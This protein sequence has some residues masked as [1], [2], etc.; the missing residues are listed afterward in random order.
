MADFDKLIDILFEK[1]E[2]IL[3]V[4]NIDF[5][6]HNLL[7]E[8]QNLSNSKVEL[9][10][11]L[12]KKGIRPPL[13]GGIAAEYL[14][15]KFLHNTLK[16]PVS[17][18][19][20][21]EIQDKELNDS[22]SLSG[23]E[24]EN[25]QLVKSKKPFSAPDPKKIENFINVFLSSAYFQELMK[26][27]VRPTEIIL[28]GESDTGLSSADIAIRFNDNVERS[29]SLKKGSATLYQAG[30]TEQL[31]TADKVDWY[32]YKGGG[33]NKLYKIFEVEVP[34][35]FTTNE[36]LYNDLSQKL[37]VKYSKNIIEFFT[38][39][40]KIIT[41]NEPSVETLALVEKNKII[42]TQLMNKF[43]DHIQSISFGRSNSESTYYILASVSSASN[44][45][46]STKSDATLSPTLQKI[47]DSL[48]KKTKKNLQSAKMQYE[49]FKNDYQSLSEKNKKVFTQICQKNNFN[50]EGGLTDFDSF[51]SEIKNFVDEKIKLINGK[52]FLHIRSK[53]HEKAQREEVF[54]NVI[55][56]RV[57]LYAIN[58]ISEFF[59]Y[60]E[61]KNEF[62]GL[63]NSMNTLFNSSTELNNFMNLQKKQ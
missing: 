46:L 25:N 39:L 10:K 12:V 44:F 8:Q 61:N 27:G 49:K 56:S 4:K 62:S 24:I 5:F 18:R 42:Y 30:R 7:N 35:S 15:V 19:G 38:V 6:I 1:K 11:Q 26:K 45:T 13:S 28:T 33:L 47:S 63:V 16:I 36:A 37:Q 50:I 53:R 48:E 29:I 3:G 57:P 2:N 9:Y 41:R 59:E 21:G 55:E 22:L 51:A 23:I 17:V 14:F 32:K 54:N 34:K 58:E 20:R 40:S 60:L 52:T 43:L 31:P